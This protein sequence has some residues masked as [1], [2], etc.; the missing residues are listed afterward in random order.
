VASFKWIATGVSVN[1][2]IGPVIPPPLINTANGSLSAN[3]VEA[4]VCRCLCDI[5]HCHINYS[6]RGWG[7]GTRGRW[8][9]SRCWSWSWARTV[10]YY[11]L[12]NSLNNDFWNIVW[13]TAST[14]AI[15][16]HFTALSTVSAILAVL[17]ILT[18][19]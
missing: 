16:I 11:W 10:N 1:T 17:I 18:S 3:L 14:S 2:V 5:C 8:C 12:N 19:M 4:A 13:I 9:W 15:A 7:W 6:R